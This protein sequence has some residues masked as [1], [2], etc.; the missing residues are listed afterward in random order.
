MQHTVAFTLPAPNGAV[1]IATF[2]ALV[3]PLPSSFRTISRIYPLLVTFNC[4]FAV[5]VTPFQLIE[6]LKYT[7][8]LQVENQLYQ[9]QYQ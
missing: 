1:E 9:Y 2:G 8:Y 4:A 7:Q 6:V 5:A 3:Y